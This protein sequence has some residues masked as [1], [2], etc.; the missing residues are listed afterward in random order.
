MRHLARSGGLLFVLILLS[1]PREVRSQAASTVPGSPMVD[2]G[3]YLY[4][5]A[6]GPR[7]ADQS[8][9]A[10]FA[11]QVRQC[12]DN[13][14]HLVE[15]AGLGT[16]HV[17]YVQVYLEDSSQIQE[18][19]EAF[20][21]YFPKDP[22]ARAV[23][24]VARVHEPPLEI[25]AVAV[26]DTKGKQAVAV[27]NWPASKA[28]S[29][30]MLTHDRLFVSTMPGSDPVTGVVPDSP[31]AQ[32]D[33]ALDRVSAVLQAAGLNNANMVFVN[34]YLTSAIPMRTMNEHYARRFEFGNTP[35]RATI[36]VSSLPE[37]ARIAYTGV[38]ARDLSRRKAVRPKNMPPSPTASPCVFAGD[39]LYCSAKSGFIP[40]P[41]GGIFTASTTDQTRQTMRNLLDNL[42]EADM[43]F[44]QV[45]STTI[46]LDDLSEAPVFA[47]VYKKYFK[48]SLPAQTTLQQLKPGDRKLEDE[49]HYPTFE[50]MSL[51]AVRNRTNSRN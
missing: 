44:D 51:I 26:R 2:A 43:N 21:A 23:L 12:L 13:V 1:Q 5:S 46:Y 39:T 35:A 27:P 6:Q 37:G 32:V 11:D 20:V 14:K 40:G 10:K 50:Q 33:M 38:A 34:P 25:T 36:E 49:V 47:D 24:G 15:A 31:A 18:L 16:D 42:E 29:A 30:G 7:R 22:P 41:N 48:G 3:D 19:N 8:T 4:I 17:V 9:P 45:V 28:F